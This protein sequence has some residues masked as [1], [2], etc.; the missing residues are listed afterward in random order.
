MKTLLPLFLLFAVSF[1]NAE[2]KKKPNVILIITDDQSWDSLRFMDGKVLTPRIDQMAREG[3]FL[4]DFNVTSTVCSPSRYSFL[5]GRYAGRCRGEKFMKEHPPGDQTQ[6]ENIGELEPDLWNFPKVLQKNGYKTGFVGKSHVIRHDWLTEH[7]PTKSAA[8][9][10]YPQDADPRDPEVNA[11][12]QRNHQKWCDEIKRYGFDFADGVYGANLKELKCDALNVHNLDW[13]VDKAINFL[14]E[15]QGDPFFLY[16]STTLH[17]GPAPWANKFSLEADPNMTGEGYVEEGFNVL[18]PRADVLRRNR[19]AG[20]PDK[21]AYALWLDDGVGAILDKVAALGL[22]EE[23]LIIFVPDHGSFRHGK[24]TL[25]DYGMRIPMLMQW[26]G[27]IK[28]HTRYDGLLANIDLAPTLLDICGVTPPDDYAMDGLSFK[29]VLFGSKEPIRKAIFGELGH[30]RCIKTKEWKYI[31]VRYPTEVQKK[32]AAG[33]TFNG[34]QGEILERPYLT[35]NGH[36]GHY[37][38]KVNPHYF[39]TDQ[40]FDMRTDP[41]ENEN[42]YGEFHDLTTELKGDLSEMLKQFKE[43]P[44]AE[45]T[46]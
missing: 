5:T 13:T 41:R 19:E 15:S 44:F 33:K 10:T 37:A 26:K 21:A 24:A 42:L 29:P 2:T 9:E 23:T 17:H 31:A 34:F 20:L 30:S 27:T 1:V 14:E 12:M 22:D 11:K 16:F 36:L 35:R 43:R 28:R 7:G 45:F 46:Q 8:M 3:L 6:V 40:L 25:Y 38:A 4:T 39:A 18:P 32:I